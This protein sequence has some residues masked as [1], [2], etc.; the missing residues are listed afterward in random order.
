[1]PK[2]KYIETPE[3][4]WELFER[5]VKHERDNPF[6]KREYVGKDG[7]EV[8]TPLPT[9]IIFEGFEC[10]LADEGIIN[11]LGDYSSDKGK[12][13]KEYATIITRI[14]KNCFANNFKG[15]AVGMFNANLIARKLGLSDNLKQTVVTEQKLLSDDDSDIEEGLELD[16]DSND[17]S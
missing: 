16:G 9:P 17:G 5:Y 8:D 11:D 3:I 14:R 6:F 10:W 2:H 7:N 1:M 12:R 15:A 13:Y 4:L